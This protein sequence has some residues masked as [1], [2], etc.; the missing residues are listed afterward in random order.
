MNI[1]DFTYCC[2]A[3]IIYAFG[4]P[5]PAYGTI[6]QQ[7]DELARWR[8]RIKAG[9]QAFEKQNSD[10]GILTL[11]VNN[12]Q[13]SAMKPVLRALKW[14]LSCTATNPQHNNQSTIY[15]YSKCLQPV[16]KPKKAK[17]R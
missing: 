11:T 5:P 7:K 15:L 3:R 14:K 4:Y 16:P 13:L 1:V 6:K 9:L 12:K 2:G 10:I 8:K 17:K